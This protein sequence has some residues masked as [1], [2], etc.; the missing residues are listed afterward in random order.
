METNK[1]YNPVSILIGFRSY[2]TLEFKED[3]FRILF[4][5]DY[6]HKFRAYTKNWG[7]D[8]DAVFDNLITDFCNLMKGNYNKRNDLPMRFSAA[9]RFGTT[10]NLFNDI[11]IQFLENTLFGKEYNSKIHNINVE[12]EQMIHFFY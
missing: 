8:E 4:D 11:K 1:K 9:S 2:S 10:T 7:L 5:S 6:A 12:D 3:G